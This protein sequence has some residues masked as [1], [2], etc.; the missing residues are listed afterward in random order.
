MDK[1]Y[2]EV[3][4]TISIRAIRDGSHGISMSA[5]DKLLGEWTDS[6]AFFLTVTPENTISICNRDGYQRYLLTLPGTS[7][8]GQQVS[9]TEAT[10]VVRI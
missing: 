6:G 3:C 1:K 9:E 7:V 8:Q 5:A 4:I 2:R 10:V